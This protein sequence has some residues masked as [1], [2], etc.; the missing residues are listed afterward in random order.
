MVI[1]N[2]LSLE[3]CTDSIFRVYRMLRY[4]RMTFHFLDKDMKRKITTTMIRPKN[5]VCLVV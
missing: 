5:R 1:Q 3:R 4:I 2:N